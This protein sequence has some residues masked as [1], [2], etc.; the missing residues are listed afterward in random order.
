MTDLYYL[1]ILLLL[2]GIGYYSIKYLFFVFVG[3]IIA[4]Y[5]SYK[6]LSP[7]FCSVRKINI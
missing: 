1:L 4:F 2:F 3:M 5:I 7:I 6:Y